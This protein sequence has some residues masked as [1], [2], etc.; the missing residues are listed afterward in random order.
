MFFPFHLLDLDYFVFSYSCWPFEMIRYR[1]KQLLLLNAF[2]I[3]TGSIFHIS[4]FLLR[5]RESAEDKK[6]ISMININIVAYLDWKKSEEKRYLANLHSSHTSLV[7]CQQ[8]CGKG[9]SH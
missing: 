3:E 8:M 1:T 4:V 9:A 5:K 6:E 2:L 7:S